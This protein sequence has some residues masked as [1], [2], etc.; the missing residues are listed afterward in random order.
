MAH[1]YSVGS[2]QS[3]RQNVFWNHIHFLNVYY[4][5]HLRIFDIT[6][7]WHFELFIMLYSSIFSND[8][9]HI[10]PVSFMNF[11]GFDGVQQT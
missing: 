4:I 5:W 6:D 11:V 10:F 1:I 2:D 9:F 8:H 3:K 7:V